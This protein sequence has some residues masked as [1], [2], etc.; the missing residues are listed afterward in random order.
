MEGWIDW[1]SWTD[2]T[3]NDYHI[4]QTNGG[5]KFWDGY[6]ADAQND[7]FSACILNW[8]EDGYN[9]DNCQYQ[10]FNALTLACE[11]EGNKGRV[12]QT[13]VWSAAFASML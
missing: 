7:K 1:N 9:F 11:N 13:A 10:E 2:A 8:A 5:G 12:F 3:L 4:L 6:H